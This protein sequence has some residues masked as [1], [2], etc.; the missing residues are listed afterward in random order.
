[1]SSVPPTEGVGDAGG[2][3]SRRVERLAKLFDLRTFIGAL[4]LIF[5]L[6]VTLEGLTAS[7]AEIAKGSNINLALWTGLIMLVTGAVFIAWMLA[8]PPQILRGTEVTADDLPEQRR[9]GH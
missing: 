4:F 8:A 1:M 6:L 7:A 5:G 9:G 2:L 3:D